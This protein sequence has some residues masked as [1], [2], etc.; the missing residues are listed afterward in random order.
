MTPEQADSAIALLW[1]IKMLLAAILM[2]LGLFAFWC[3]GAWRR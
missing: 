3:T 1:W 2:I